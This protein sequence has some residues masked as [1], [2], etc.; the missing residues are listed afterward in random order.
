MAATLSFTTRNY[1]IEPPRNITEI[2]QYGAEDDLVSVTAV[3]LTDYCDS[4]GN[5]DGTGTSFAF[6]GHRYYKNG[7]ERPT[8]SVFIRP[9]YGGG[10]THDVTQEEL[11]DEL[12][13]PY[14]KEEEEPA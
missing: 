3:V 7:K 9:T 11:L 2:G 1:T 6:Y 4:N 14:T 8:E 5:P 12:G 13:I 10:Q